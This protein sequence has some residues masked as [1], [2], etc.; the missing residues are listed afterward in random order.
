MANASVHALSTGS[1]TLPERFF[2]T[3]ADDTA[4]KRVPSLSFLVQ[5]TSSAHET[6][7]IVFDLG[8]RRDI[9]LYPSSLQKHC[10]SRSPMTTQPDAVASLRKGGLSVDDIDF[11]VFSHVHYDHVGLPKDFTNPR[12]KF[13]V[14]PDALDLL[15]GKTQL[16]IGS[17]SFFEPDLLPPER[18]IEL[19][20]PPLGSNA[21]L[22]STQPLPLKAEL[23]TDTPLILSW[24][25]RPLPGWENTM[26][27]FGDGT[28]YILNAPGHLPGHINL[29]VRVSNDPVKFVCLAGDACHDIRLFTGERDIAT[30]TDDTGRQCCIHYDIPRAKQTIAR[31]AR[32]QQE[33]IE[34][35]GV[36][37]EVEVVF[38]HNWQWEEDAVK[39]GRFWPGKL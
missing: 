23:A 16:N 11:V 13:I 17:H 28:I 27:I 33:G 24:S 31:L 7:R 6:T 18:T 3:P 37:A 26:D 12:T 1:L 15:S 2:I 32:L 22:A 5:H 36:R 25:S 20:N 29:L 21:V 39:R 34:I 19:P 9:S 14:G 35:D 30:W 38:A 4:K 10:A 8:L